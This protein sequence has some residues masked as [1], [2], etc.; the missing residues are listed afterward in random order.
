VTA[1]AYRAG[2]EVY[3]KT[4]LNFERLRNYPG[5]TEPEPTEAPEVFRYLN[6]GGNGLVEIS[7]A[8]KVG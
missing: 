6:K 1:R 5:F 8:K 2:C 4:N 7:K 3:H